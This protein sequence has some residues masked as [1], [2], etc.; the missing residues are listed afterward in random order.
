MKKDWIPIMIQTGKLKMKFTNLIN[1]YLI[2]LCLFLPIIFTFFSLF[3]KY[4]LNSSTGVKSPK[5]LVIATLPFGL[6]AI[7]FYF[8]QKNKLKFKT[9]ETSMPIEKVKDI[10]EMTAKQHE[11]HTEIMDEKIIIVKTHTKWTSGS[12]GEQITIIFDNSRI[13]INSIC[14]PNKGASV[15]SMG[16]S[17]GRNKN[18]INTLI[19][20][21]KTAN[22]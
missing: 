12:S 21:I 15:I 5:E 17:M 19:R 4:V 1:H 13:M 10:I 8:I 7:I 3:Q 9:I 14:D 2:V 22:S 16:N 18:N 20:N 11:W 6:I